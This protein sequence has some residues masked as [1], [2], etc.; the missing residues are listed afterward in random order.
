MKKKTYIISILLC[1]VFVVSAATP[2]EKHSFR[3]SKNLTIFNSLFRELDL[4]YVDTLNYDK[5]VK[6]TIDN[7]LEKLDPYTVYMPEEETDDLTFMTTG[8]YAGIGA[9]IM[10]KDKDICISEPYEGM[11]AQ[12]NGIRAGDII[13]EIDGYKVE[14]MSVSDVSA[15]LKGTPNTTIKLKL[16]RPGEKKNLEIAFLREKIQ[17]NPVAY[18]A[19]VA[20]KTGYVMLREFTDRAAIEVKN[21]VNDLVKNHKIE[22]LVLDIRN[23]GGGLIDEAVKIV[24]YF[25]PKGTDVVTTKGK[26]SE[27]DR[28]YKTPTEPIFPNMKLAILT[29]RSSA[30]ASEILAGSIQDLDRGVIIGERTFGKGLVQN[31]RPIGFGGHLKV[32]TAKYYIPSGRCIQAIDYSHRNEDGSVGRVPDSLT[33]EFLTR[34]GRKVRD[35]GGIIPDSLTKDERKLNIAYYIFVQNLYFDYATLYVQRHPTIASP[36]DFKLTDEDF[37]AFANYLIEKKF[38]YTT[39]TEKYYNELLEVAKYE[40]LD[41]RAKAEF[42]A[43]KAKLMP[44]ISKSIEENKDDIADLLSLEIIK[45][46]YYQKGEIQYSLRTDKDLKVALDLLKTNDSYSKILAKKQ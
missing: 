34:N 16:K 15:R 12:R 32:T 33:H 19:V 35:G 45:R 7:M 3:I 2:A 40:S 22:S 42:E 43:L 9:L 30:S 10:K 38:T 23:N 20:D 28:T 24:G 27:S 44:D 4:Y 41:T 5:M 21:A 29:N 36:S 31:I 17:V 13:L 18:S 11:P 26:N 37:K 39:Q 25:V 6:T 8:E 1:L 14:G 46:Y